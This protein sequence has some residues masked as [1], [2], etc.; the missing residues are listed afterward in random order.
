MPSASSTIARL[1][2]SC[3][4]PGPRSRS[5]PNWPTSSTASGSSMKLIYMPVGIISGILAG[6]LARKGFDRVWELIDDEDPP[7]PDQRDAS[8]TKLIA[9]LAI[10]GA[11]FR[12]T[13][14]IVERGARG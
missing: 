6:M 7:G 11:V 1:W 8:L 12:L 4:P 13:K 9:A 14:G 5:S 2:S 3:E 10:E